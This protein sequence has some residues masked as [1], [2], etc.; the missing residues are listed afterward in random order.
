M[1]SKDPFESYDGCN[2]EGDLATCITGKFDLLEAGERLHFI[3][4]RKLAGS[5]SEQEYVFKYFKD[6]IFNENTELFPDITQAIHDGIKND[7]KRFLN[8]LSFLSGAELENA[9]RE[10]FFQDY[11]EVMGIDTSRFSE[12]TSLFG[13]TE[14]DDFLPLDDDGMLF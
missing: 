13:N 10:E 11:A 7:D 3:L 1:Y 5:F 2:E 4:A 9:W 6:D 8:A 14:E 12:N